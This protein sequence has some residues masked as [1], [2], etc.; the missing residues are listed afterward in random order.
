MPQHVADRTWQM[1]K[2]TSWKCERDAI[3]DTG[4]DVDTK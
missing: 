2:K 4:G 1:G 3:H